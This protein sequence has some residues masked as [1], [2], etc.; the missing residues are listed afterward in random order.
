LYPGFTLLANAFGRDEAERTELRH[1]I[2]M[3]VYSLGL[4]FLEQRALFG[5]PRATKTC[6]T[7]PNGGG[8][9]R[10]PAAP[11][12]DQKRFSSR[13][14]TSQSSQ[15]GAS[16]SASDF[17]VPTVTSFA[18]GAPPRGGPRFFAPRNPRMRRIDRIL[19]PRAAVCLLLP[20][21]VTLNWGCTGRLSGNGPSG[22]E[23]TPNVAPAGS[24]AGGGASMGPSV[25]D[26]EQAKQN[27]D[28][29]AIASGYFPNTAAL[30]AKK[31]VSRLT[32][33]Q[34][35]NTTRALLPQHYSTSAVASVPADPLQTNYEYAENLGFNAANFTPYITWVTQIANS[36]RS[37]P[38]DVISCAGNSPSCLSEQARQFVKQAFRGAVSEAQLAH[39]DDFFNTSVNAI[40]IAAATADLVDVTLTSPSYV[41]RDEVQ[42]NG[43]GVLAPAQLLQN[44]SYT[45]ADSPP[46]AVGLSSLAPAAAVQTT[47]DMQRTVDQVLATA[48]ARAKLLKFFVS[49]LEVKEPEEFTIA[50]SAFPEF[51]P[52][53]AAAVVTET[54]QFL[55]HQLSSAAPKLKDLTESTQSFVQDSMSF[56]YGLKSP[57]ASAPV[58]LDPSQRLGVFTLPGVLAS[59]SGPTTTRLVK[60][61][62]FFTRK[63]MCLKL[64]NPPAGTDTSLPM[65][66]GASERQ[67]VEG[68]TNKAPCSGCHTYINPF[69]FMLENYDAI[70][71]W[72]TTDQGIPIDPNISVGFLGTGQFSAS[73]PIE[74]L[75]GFTRSTLFQQC[76]ARQ[77]FR[78][79]LGRDETSDDDP[80][81]RQMFF[82]FANQD[83][84]D[85]LGMLRTLAGSGALSRRLEAP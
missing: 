18:R 32:R 64:G 43:S 37:N 35:D 24:G 21:A 78:F 63:V 68:V 56:I 9:G 61:G 30:D 8:R 82:D 6:S 40:G 51:T 20:A 58:D 76:F 25:I 26:Q 29:Y 39:F 54:K 11:T 57:S 5:M 70:G 73:S 13:R 15:P 31:R 3:V 2:W 77:L 66:M 22:L 34:L 80:L 50:S 1:I 67:R 17:F 69:G 38:A 33:S 47:S 23:P 59:H 52:E 46:E 36:V 85:I 75:K 45:L 44:I 53:V 27:P 48:E 71:R 12:Y 74:A 7:T 10:A 19:R 84:Q 83:Q 81:L 4:S 28:L 42:S 65:T 49:W 16:K 41:F 79:Y 72:R 62:V 60:R 55:Q 14:T